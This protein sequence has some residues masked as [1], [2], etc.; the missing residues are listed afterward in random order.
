MAD[1]RI[2]GRCV[3]HIHQSSPPGWNEPLVCLLAGCTEK[4]TVLN[5]SEAPQLMVDHAMIESDMSS[6]CELVSNSI[7]PANN[8]QPVID[9]S[10]KGCADSAL[11]GSVMLDTQCLIVNSKQCFRIW[12]S[13]RDAGRM[14]AAACT[15]P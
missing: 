8:G 11:Y 12:F 1:K 14:D 5:F 3:K 15:E 13:S 10:L 4:L 2:D 6:A 7:F 9:G